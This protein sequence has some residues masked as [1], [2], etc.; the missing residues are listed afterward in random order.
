M[1]SSD[2][3]ARC[4]ARRNLDWEAHVPRKPRRF[5][6]AGV[7]WNYVAMDQAIRDAG[8]DEKDVI[9]ERTG[10]I[11]G[12]GGPSTRAIVARRRRHPR[13]G[14]KQ[15]R[16]VRGAEGHVLGPLGGARHG[17]PDQ[18]RQLLDLVGLRHLAPTASAMPPSSSSGA[19]RT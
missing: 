18:G 7:G 1:P 8:L 15:G 11:M 12:S 16:P 4:T 2:S 6:G 19:S 14:P 9:N 17:L 13:K 5:M 10:I 3:A